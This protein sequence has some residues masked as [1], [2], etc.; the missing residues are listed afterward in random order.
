MSGDSLEQSPEYVRAR[1]VLIDALEA[2]GPHRKA[3]VLVGAQ[4]IYQRVGAGHLQVAPFTTDGDLALNPDVLEDAPLLAE[5]LQA[6]G[7]A[8]AQRP[9]TWA[10]DSV[11]ID[12]MV[13][14]A[15][16]GAGRRGARLGPHGS[17]VA[18]K[19]NGLEAAIVNHETFKLA[20]LDPVD[21][22]TVEVAVA[23]LSA[24]LV[25]KL[26]KLA[27]REGS[28]DRWSPKDGLD[29]LRILQGGDLTDLGATLAELEAHPLAGPVTREAR[30]LLRVLFGTR[31]AHGIAMAIRASVGVED[32]ATVAA[33]CV[34]LCGE[35]LD[36]WEA[37]AI[38]QAP[39][40]EGPR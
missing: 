29:V 10:R 24:L 40:P 15:V 22:R 6:G 18:R 4:A 36:V 27:E 39:A 37:R 7:F 35:L 25:A 13:P 34:L 19:T 21:E 26:H 2:L 30:I 1:R 33:A 3:V 12:L 14:A 8:L 38:D 11:Q 5:A 31:T 32:P 17:D 23:G 9:G 20:A 28:P 16:G